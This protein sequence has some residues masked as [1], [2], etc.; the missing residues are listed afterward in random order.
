MNK[1]FYKGICALLCSVP[2]VL[3]AQT[4]IKITGE[5]RSYKE[6][7]ALFT[8]EHYAASIPSLE[9]YIKA[10]KDA[11]LIQEAQYMLAV[12]NFK[13]NDSKRVDLLKEYVTKYPDTPYL[14]NINSYIAAALFFEEDY[15]EAVKYYDTVDFELLP[16]EEFEDNIY[17]F[18]ISNLK[19][20][21]TTKAA[22]WF[23]LLQ[24]QGKKHRED[25]QYYTSYIKYTERKYDEALDGFVA[26]QKSRKY[27]DLVPY[28][29]AS[30]YYFKGDFAKTIEIGNQYL[31]GRRSLRSNPEMN[32]VIAEASFALDKYEATIQ[33][34][35][36][37]LNEGLNLNRSAMY[38]LG[39]SYYRLGTFTKA[40]EAFGV[41]ANGDDLLAQ[42]ANLHLGLS[43][44]GLSDRTN[45]RMAFQQAAAINGDAQI[46][47]K[48][49]YNYALTIHE[50]SYS[51]FG[52]SVDVFERFLTE[53][54]NSIYTDKVSDYLAEL[55]MNTRS[56]EAAMKSINRISNPSVRILEA[57][58]KIL[59]QL[60]TETFA[61]Q[62][63]EQA[64]KYF[65]NSLALGQYNRQ[66]KADAAY[67]RGESYY[68]LG[69]DRS[70]TRDFRDYLSL[71]PKK[72]GEMYALAFYNLGY[73]AFNNKKYEEAEGLFSSYTQYEQGD[74]RLALADAFNRRGDSF[75]Q[76]RAF[77]QAKGNYTRAL[78]TDKAV[79]DYSLFQLSLVAGLQKQYN[80]KV[81]Y[82]SQ[83]VA[84]YP[85]SPYLPQAQYEE[86]RAYVDLRQNN[87]A[88]SSFNRLI[89]KYPTNSFSRKATA[90]VGLLYYQDGNYNEAIRTYKAVLQNY[91]GSEEAK[92]AMKDLRSI[93]VDLNRVDE[94]AAL[95][96]SLPGGIRIAATEQDSLTYIA[97]EK[98][99]MNQQREEAEVSFER[100]LSSYP[101]GAFSLN[102]HYYLAVLNNHSKNTDKVITHTNELLK[103]QGNPYYEEALYMQSVIY[104]DRKE[105]NKSLELFKDLAEKTTSP[106][107]LEYALTGRLH[108]AVYLKDTNEIIPAS[109]ELLKI[110]K[111]S[112]ELKNEALYYRGKSFY[113]NK[114]YSGAIQDFKLV[115]KDTRT[116]YGAEA[117]YLLADIYYKTNKYGAAEKELLQFI[118]QSTPHAY[119]L[120]RGFVLLADVYMAEGK[121]LEARQYLLSLQQNYPN[122]DDIAEMITTRL[123]KLKTDEQE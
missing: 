34:F 72:S 60:G 58:Q 112:P 35:T 31:N 106:D 39:M 20:G 88:I 86:G 68:R 45:A 17:R 85:N 1:N 75:L 3:N 107:R 92:M 7:K 62:D 10:N 71:T 16:N 52:E 43:Y 79:G 53:F 91:P 119:W 50:T 115:S 30:C 81:K 84:D 102:A 109:T 67:W 118:E 64:I 36:V 98:R 82:I 54:P 8:N 22:V 24:M 32:R 14:N 83:L 74:N 110:G 70:A 4:S 42:N 87:Q 104:Y 103:L 120:A 44:L 59:F 66:T 41:A 111:L 90:E 49:M 57:K 28:Y 96:S 12:A 100:Y 25:G 78:N 2:L 56:Y 105:Y 37:C 65:S 38:K 108:A 21:N 121:E 33:H 47:E 97:A 23:N 5:E 123:N 117:K 61:N 113:V 122:N 114:E 73:I 40:I 55:Y 51:A 26:L 89:A 80:E 69:D 116:L 15:V 27:E 13:L 63:Y 9:A 11:S 94:Y 29:I 76:K 99:Y 95:A 18:A 46:R 93:Y 48:A 6:G 19:A 77:I 101:N